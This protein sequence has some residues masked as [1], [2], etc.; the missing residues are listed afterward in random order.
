MMQWSERSRK[1]VEACRGA[2]FYVLL[3]SF[4]AN[5]LMLAVPIYSLQVLDRVISSGSAET[6]MMLTLVVVL[7]LVALTLLQFARGSLLMRAGAWVEEKLAPLVFAQTVSAAASV[8]PLGAGQGLRDLSLL[9]SF[10]SGGAFAAILDAP[11]ALIF[12]AVLFAIHPII[13]GLTVFGALVLFGLALLDESRARPLQEAAS[14]HFAR[15][16]GQL[17]MA[18]RNAEAVEAMGM[19]PHILSNWRGRYGVALD[20]Q[21]QASH[22]A[23][24]V[25]SAS[26]FV[27]YFLQIAVIGVAADLALHNMLSAGAIIA[28]SILVSRALAPFETIIS[29]WTQFTSAREAFHR[30][31]ET[32]EQGNEREEEISLPDPQGALSLEN[33]SYMPQG[34]KK[35]TIRNISAR[36]RPGEIIGLIGPSGAGKSTLSRL[37]TG[38]LKPSAGSARLDGAEIWRWNRADF[39]RHVGY[40]PQDIELFAGTVRDNIAR[41]DADA[42][43]E[44]V[45]DAARRAGVHDL[46]LRLPAGYQ[47]EIGVGGAI[48]SGGQRQRIALARALFGNPRLLVLDEPG[49]NLD[50]DGEQALVQALHRARQDGATVVLIAHRP[51]L[52]MIADRI[53]LLK[54]GELALFGPRDEV[55]EKLGANRVTDFNEARAGKVKAPA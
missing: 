42:P 50:G 27:R 34:A 53:M 12:L 45:V 14:K 6:L 35:P 41:M 44:L 1:Y 30:L 55:M 47:T 46:I 48:L 9:R 32:L 2:L 24:K 31:R 28:A 40:L 16:A 37:L 26:R 15:N 4:F 10:L 22:R 21:G 18:A 52:M 33:L 49:S 38:V 7:A 19:L 51:S 39:G 20:L 5:L 23:A 8:K 54:D 3:F 11:W 25:G 17:E 13:G 43:D 36:I 29:A